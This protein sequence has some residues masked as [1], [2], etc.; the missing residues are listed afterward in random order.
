MGRR[1]CAMC[2]TRE[3]HFLWD[4]FRRCRSYSKAAE[5]EDAMVMKISQ[6]REGSLGL[7]R[8]R[9]GAGVSDEVERGIWVFSFKGERAHPAFDIQGFQLP[10]T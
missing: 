7:K 8:G 6:F 5:K 3:H 1:S 9:P 2:D 10:L 4:F